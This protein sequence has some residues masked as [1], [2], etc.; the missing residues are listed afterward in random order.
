MRA[1]QAD[2][3][4]IS[5]QYDQPRL[6]ILH[7]I[8]SLTIEGGGADRVAFELARAQAARSHKVSVLCFHYKNRPQMFD[9][10]ELR[11]TRLAD[12][13]RLG[14][15]LGLS[16]HFAPALYAAAQRS[17]ILHVHG[18]W[19]YIQVQ[20]RQISRRL[21]KPYIYQPH[22]SFE[23]YRLRYKSLRKS[24]W[25]RAF[26]RRNVAGAASVVV[27]S[28]RDRREVTTI[29]PSCRTDILPNAGGISD[30]RLEA[31]EFARRYPGLEPG[32]YYLFFGRI[33]FH[34]G[35][36]ILIR[37]YARIG[38]GDRPALA[39]VGPDHNNTRAA[40]LAM[41]R[42]RGLDDVH[43]FGMTSGEEEKAT[44]LSGARCFIL[45]SYSEN[46]G[47]TVLESMLAETPVIVSRET[48]WEGLERLGAGL[49]IDP[50]EDALL[51]A[52]KRFEEMPNASCEAMVAR[53][54]E[55]AAQFS[56]AAIAEQAEGIYAA[57]IE[58]HKMLVG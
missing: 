33:D 16:R 48:A 19:R 23:A 55:V 49:V 10:P 29:F 54:R 3:P 7:I 28:E 38:A 42:D 46:F 36:D 35:V 31:T 9:A 50:T 52:L 12:P 41:V 53:A 43:F 6:R 24:I 17:D 8:E 56:W 15:G 22:G 58:R 26:E 57:A 20:C 14:Q 30:E 40:L 37:A 2:A 39:I 1:S 47:L 27:E 44:L 13:G 21:G 4:G 32:R 5:G 18:V 11:I 51:A 34:K 25:L 45:P